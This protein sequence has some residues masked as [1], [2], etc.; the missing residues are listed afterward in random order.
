MICGYI[1]EEK[2]GEPIENALIELISDNFKIS[3]MDWNFTFTDA[4]GYYEIMVADSYFHRN[5]I[6]AC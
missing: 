5:G 1:T 6:S 3:H 4:D 2:S